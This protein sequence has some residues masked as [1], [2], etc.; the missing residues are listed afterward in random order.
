MNQNK[1]IALGLWP[2]AGVTTIGVTRDDALATIQAAID[3]GITT[4]DTAFSYGY[5]GE[6]DRILGE[7]LRKHRERFY[8]I[9][10]VGQRWTASHER[11]IDGS[12]KQLTADAEESLKRL[13]I[14]QFDLLML[15]M[16]DP[17]IDIETSAATIATLQRRGLCRDTGV[18]N[19]TADQRRAFANSAA[20][21]AIQTPLNLLQREALNELVPECIVDDC[22]VYVYWTLMKGLLA[23]KITRDH[24][25]AEGDSRPKYPIFQGEARRRTHDI[26]DALQPIA[27]ASGMTIAQLSISWAVSQPGITAALV[28]ARRPDQ[29]LETCNAGRRSKEIVDQIDAVVQQ[30]GG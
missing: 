17:N 12:E 19:I 10:K 11:A 1:P 13:G 16:V 3:N 8:V 27:D 4:F 6:S 9:G 14:D 18:C 23:G 28:G 25:F 15:H 24:Q 29:I 20:C 2:I 30:H 22:N 26:L 5:D 21:N 7:F